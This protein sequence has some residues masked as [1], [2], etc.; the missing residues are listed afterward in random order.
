LTG[1]ENLLTELGAGEIDLLSGVLSTVGEWAGD[2][3]RSDFRNLD[4]AGENS[5]L[6]SSSDPGD[7]SGKSNNLVSEVSP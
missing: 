7:L 1:T 5:F 4:G 6:Y 2:G 3:E